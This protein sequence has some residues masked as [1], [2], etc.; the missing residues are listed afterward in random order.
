MKTLI[1]AALAAGSMIGGAAQAELTV[2]APAEIEATASIEVT[3]AAEL[4]SALASELPVFEMTAPQAALA[5]PTIAEVNGDVEGTV[6]ETDLGTQRGGAAIV[7]ADQDLNQV[8]VGNV[9][10]GDYVAGNITVSDNAFSNFTG[11]GNV[12]INTGGLSSIQSGIN[13]TINTN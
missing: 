10:M 2:P 1:K 12:L 8:T 7:V 9:L 13:V 11:I 4:P 6:S 5:L 3:T